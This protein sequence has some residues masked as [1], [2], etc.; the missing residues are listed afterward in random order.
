M[1]ISNFIGKFVTLNISNFIGCVWVYLKVKLN[2]KY[3][4]EGIIWNIYL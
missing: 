2:I 3:F 4:F 1:N